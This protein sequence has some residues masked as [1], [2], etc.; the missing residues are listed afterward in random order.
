MKTISLKISIEIEKNRWK[1]QQNLPIVLASISVRNQA[2]IRQIRTQINKKKIKLEL[3]I[4]KGKNF[5][6]YI[7]WN[8]FSPNS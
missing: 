3:E 7:D 1:Q 6:N 4:S 8:F 2:L 5:P